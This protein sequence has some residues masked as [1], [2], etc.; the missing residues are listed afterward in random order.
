MEVNTCYEMIPLPNDSSLALEYTVKC[1]CN[2][3][4]FILKYMAR[5]G[6]P[7]F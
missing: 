7:Y 6:G 5:Y 3:K 1:Y 2:M 4:V